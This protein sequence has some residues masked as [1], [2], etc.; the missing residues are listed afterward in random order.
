MVGKSSADAEEGHPLT[1]DDGIEN[2]GGVEED[3]EKE[4]NERC[5]NDK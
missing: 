4:A 3:E 1:T 5:K 2:E